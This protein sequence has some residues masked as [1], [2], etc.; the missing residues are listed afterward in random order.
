M[1]RRR[2]LVRNVAEYVA[3]RGVIALT[4]LLPRRAIPAVSRALGV[5][6]HTAL[7]G[8]RRV[9]YQNVALAYRGAPDAPDP[10][11]LSKAS[12]ANLCRSFLELF[13][14]PPAD[15]P[16]ELLAAVKFDRGLTPERL[17]QRVGPGPV[18]YT[19]G[20]FGAWEIAGAVSGALGTPVTSLV[21]PLDNP[22]L[23]AYLARIRMRF[24]Q[25]LASNRGGFRQ[26]FEDL[27]NGR[28]VAVLVDLNMKRQGA[29]FVDFFGV[30]AA[31]AKTPAVLALR[32]GR[33]L[34]P[35]FCHRTAEAY[36]FEIE[37][38]EPIAPR[39]H[40]QDRDEE[41]LRLVTEVTRVVEQRVRA[42]PEQWLWT[43]RRWKTRPDGESSA[44]ASSR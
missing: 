6:L 5:I 10:A 25:K 24:G 1:S 11:R 19:V 9:V 18:I 32:S 35:V 34:V 14:I 28:S 39:L 29:V 41:T 4:R 43:H 44:E 26:L 42:T 15:R 3:A 30:K 16:E 13:L 17:A 40:S 27:A 7:R 8:R 20:H 38:A 12:F 36:R 22:L 21:R 23:E 31:T 33:P 37:V 2:S